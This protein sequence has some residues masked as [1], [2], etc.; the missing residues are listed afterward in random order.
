MKAGSYLFSFKR[1]KKNDN[2]NNI[3]ASKSVSG[4]GGSQGEIIIK[5]DHDDNYKPLSLRWRF[6]NL[7]SWKKKSLYKLRHWFV[8]S[9]LFKIVSIF[10]AIALVSTLAFFF[11]CCGCHI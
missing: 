9:F 8:D 4:G 3:G 11:F 2:G 7:S 6:K 5:R 1:L 10:E